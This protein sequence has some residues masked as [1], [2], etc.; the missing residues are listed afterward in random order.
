[1]EQVPRISDKS[2]DMS[3][4]NEKE[5]NKTPELSNSVEFSSYNLSVIFDPSTSS[6]SGNLTVNYYNNDPVGFEQIPFHLFLPGMQY[7]SREGD[8]EILNVTTVSEPKTPLNFTVDEPAQLLWVN[9]S[10]TLNPYQRTF[11][12][13]EF[14]SI[15]PDGGIDRANSHGPVGNRIYKFTSFYPM[16]CVYDEYDGWNTDPYLDVGDPFYHDMAYY[17]LSIEAPQDMV[18]TATGELVEQIPNGSNITYHFDPVF[19]VR[20]VTFAASEDYIVESAIINGVNISVYY[21]PSFWCVRI[22]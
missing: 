20:E 5:L 13:I 16:P 9:L 7:V 6:V 10:T 22:T 3:R 12:E 14:H 18:I 1:M 2:K 4:I 15:I 21:I 8:I 11:F 17:N 19:P